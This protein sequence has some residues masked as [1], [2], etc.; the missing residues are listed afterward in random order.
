MLERLGVSHCQKTAQ[1]RRL[2]INIPEL[3]NMIISEQPKHLLVLWLADMCICGGDLLLQQI[4]LT[5][6]MV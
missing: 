5:P 6:L 1:V 4:L 3:L 2:A